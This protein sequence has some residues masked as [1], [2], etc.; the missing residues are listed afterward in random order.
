MRSY[1]VIARVRP[2]NNQG[3]FGILWCLTRIKA[4]LCFNGIVLVRQL[5]FGLATLQGLSSGR[6]RMAHRGVVLAAR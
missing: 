1:A 2:Q 4:R 3:S 6:T 5:V